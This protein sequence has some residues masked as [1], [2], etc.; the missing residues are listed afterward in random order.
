MAL[1]FSLLAAMTTTYA[2]L[3]DNKEIID[4]LNSESYAAVFRANEFENMTQSEFKAT[5]LMDLDSSEMLKTLRSMKHYRST[6]S[7]LPASWDWRDHDAVTAVKNQESC[8]TCW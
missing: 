5:R 2:I 1:C 3:P 4:R 7:D 8:G 6:L